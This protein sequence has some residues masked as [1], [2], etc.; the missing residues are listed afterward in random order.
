MTGTERR[1]IETIRR[2]LAAFAAGDIE[3]VRALL[4]PDAEVRFPAAGVFKGQY[5]GIAEIFEFFGQFPLCQ[6][7]CRLNRFGTFGGADSSK[8]LD[9][10]KRI[11]IG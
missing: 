8:W 10:D 2:V 9:T 7:S 6:D 1:N 3:T 4:L 11:R 5:K